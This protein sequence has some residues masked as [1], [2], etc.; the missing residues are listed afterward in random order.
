MLCVFYHNKK[1]FGGKES[2]VSKEA[3]TNCNRRILQMRCISQKCTPFGSDTLASVLEK[4][5]LESQ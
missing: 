1:K 2:R 3:N 4:C 5:S